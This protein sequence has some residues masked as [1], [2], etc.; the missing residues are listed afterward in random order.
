MCVFLSFIFSVRLKTGYNCVLIW[1]QPYDWRWKL[2]CPVFSHL[3]LPFGM[4]FSHIQSRFDYFTLQKNK[5]KKKNQP[6]RL[7]RTTLNYCSFCWKACWTRTLIESKID[8]DECEYCV[9]VDYEE[10]HQITTEAIT[11]REIGFPFYSF[12]RSRIIITEKHTF[13]ESIY[14]THEC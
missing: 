3:S 4:N 11:L 13:R 2:Y 1:V 7:H 10:L 12:V 9:V 8:C 6:E 14:I 5:K